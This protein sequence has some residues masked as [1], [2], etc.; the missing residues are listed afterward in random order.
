[1]PYPLKVAIHIDTFDTHRYL[2]KC[3]RTRKQSNS[4]QLRDKQIKTRQHVH[5]SQ[6]A[7]KCA[8]RCPARWMHLRYH[9]YV[10]KRGEQQRNLSNHCFNRETNKSKLI[11]M[12]CHHNLLTNALCDGTENP[13]CSLFQCLRSPSSESHNH[14][15][16]AA[17]AARQ[18]SPLDLKTHVTSSIA[19]LIWTFENR[20][21]PHIFNSLLP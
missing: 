17:R 6:C 19:S 1:M 16:G 18:P 9:K 5:S 15:K 13:H 4:N 20:H 21:D 2:G 12:C 8:V 11:N 14:H 3:L 10:Q 7:N